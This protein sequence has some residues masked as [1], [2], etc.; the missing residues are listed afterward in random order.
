MP[1]P[2]TVRAI[3]QDAG[4]DLVR[5]GPADPGE[6][7]VKFLSWL[8]A[9]R[10][11][12]MQYLAANTERI[13]DPTKWRP[14]VR[15]AITL[16]VDYGA[17]PV[18]L[19]GG[20]RVA[21]YAAGRDYHRWMRERVFALREALEAAGAPFG[22]MNGGTD[23][24]PVL[25]RAL[26]IRSGIGF[27][28]KSAMV[29]SPTHGPYLQLAE[30]LTGM[31]LPPD[32]PSPGSCGTCTACLDACPTGAIVAPFEIDARRCL[33]YTTIEHRGFV[34][35][36]L[37]T[38]QGEWLF[39]CDICLEVCPFTKR[40]QRAALRGE[41]RPRDLRP[42]R[43]VETWT[44]VDVLA[45]DAARYDADFVGTAMRRATLSGMRRNAAI[46]LGNR[47]DESALP[48]LER[49]LS[50]ADPVVRG[51]SA[52]AIGRIDAKSPSL[53]RAL[54]RESDDR[55]RD[56]LVAAIS[57]EAPPVAR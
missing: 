24:V 1:S 54:A 11:G 36:D 33:S 7:G 25:E 46:V 14:G 22:S 51:H 55:V 20:G 10:H 5:F 8:E 32:A 30:L 21:R 29:I 39:G 3:A 15:S 9:G 57:G 16:A 28:A 43:V 17:A 27:L 18:E 23:A 6:H 19:P 13:L 2:E 4:F 34:P 42:H 40:S 47:G 53:E 50:D 48:H 41:Q 26:A 56:E 44:L 37:R 31:D 12:D 38:P 35:P 49:A 52:W 45:L